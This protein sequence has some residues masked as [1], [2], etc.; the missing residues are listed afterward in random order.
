MAP[1]P[2]PPALAGTATPGVYDGISVGGGTGK[3]TFDLWMD[4]D[5]NPGMSFFEFA[6]GNIFE[7]V[8]KDVGTGTAN[9]T[10]L[11]EM[12]TSASADQYGLFLRNRSSWRQCGCPWTSNATA[13][14]L[15]LV[16][17]ML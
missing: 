6:K 10:W 1:P 4:V 9:G 7:G 14:F 3:P 13:L 15:L 11:F 2:V 5:V 16:E 17:A 12:I 8:T